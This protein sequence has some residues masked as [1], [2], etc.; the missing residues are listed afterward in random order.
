[1]KAADLFQY[2]GAFANAPGKP[3]IEEI[4]AYI[5]ETYEVYQ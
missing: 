4:K 1:M 5:K 2:D 3:G